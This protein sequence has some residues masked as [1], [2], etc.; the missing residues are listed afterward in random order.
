MALKTLDVSRQ[1]FD[2]ILVLDFE[3]TCDDKK[4][5]TPQE[6]IEFPILMVDTK[7]FE[8]HSTFHQYVEPQ[9]NKNL[10]EF[11]TNLTGITNQMINGQPNLEQ[12]LKLFDEWLKSKKELTMDESQKNKNFTFLT[13]GDWDLKTMLPEQCKQFNIMHAEYFNSWINLKKA[14]CKYTGTFPRGMT[15]MLDDLDI[16]L[17]GRHHSGIDDCRNIA[18]IVKKMG[19]GGHIFKNTTYSKS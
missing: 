11:C 6:I 13:C 17:E 1:V 12:T 5:I 8:I 7:S 10:S 18:K 15:R 14:Y 4:K 3:A 2:Y 9:V 19:M 16:K